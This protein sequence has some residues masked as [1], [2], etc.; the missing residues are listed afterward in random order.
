M[1]RIGYSIFPTI[2]NNNVGLDL[3]SQDTS[4]STSTSTSPTTISKSNKVSIN[5]SPNVPFSIIFT[6][7]NYNQLNLTNIN[8]YFF[9]FNININTDSNND[10]VIFT[11]NNVG[12]LLHIPQYITSSSNDCEIDITLLEIMNKNCYYQ[13]NSNDYYLDDRQTKLALLND[14]NFDI[15]IISSDIIVNIGGNGANL[16]NYNFNKNININSRYFYYNDNSTSYIYTLNSGLNSFDLNYDT[17]LTNCISN[18]LKF[19]WKLN[20]DMYITNINTDYN[21]ETGFLQ[22]YDICNNYFNDT[23]ISNDKS[24]INIDLMHIWHNFLFDSNGTKIELSFEF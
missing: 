16:N 1:C 5:S 2:I 10:N 17:I 19:E 15:N 20:C 8:E 23:N 7:S 18:N 24:T 11:N 14:I 9:Q 3:E 22:I 12:G 6:I 13:Y 21:N 4:T